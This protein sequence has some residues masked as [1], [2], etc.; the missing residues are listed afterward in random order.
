MDKELISAVVLMAGAL[1]AVIM[2]LLR[3]KKN[4]AAPAAPAA[5]DYEDQPITRREFQHGLRGLAQVL[6]NALIFIQRDDTDEAIRTVESWQVLQDA[7][8]GGR[9]YE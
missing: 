4:G 5:I 8:R 6:T 7:K 1:V 2:A 3:W 9:R